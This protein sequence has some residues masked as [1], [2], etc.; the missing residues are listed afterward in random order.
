MSEA[1]TVTLTREQSEM[2]RSLVYHRLAQ[3][4]P[5]AQADYLDELVDQFEQAELGP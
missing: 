2:V 5:K 4:P 1:V 3:E